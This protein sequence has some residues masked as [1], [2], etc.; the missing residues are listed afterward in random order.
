MC[1]MSS[2]TELLSIHCTQKYIFNTGVLPWGYSTSTMKTLNL[3]QWKS[4]QITKK[5]TQCQP[6]LTTSTGLLSFWHYNLFHCAHLFIV[7]TTQQKDF[8]A[9][10]VNLLLRIIGLVLRNNWLGSGEILKRIMG[11]F[12]GLIGTSLNWGYGGWCMVFAVGSG[13]WCL[14]SSLAVI[15]VDLKYM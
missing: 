5:T 10:N 13:K 1:L 12:W 7:F 6:A 4:L 2:L 14:S 11:R 3:S 15:V 8:F 9:K